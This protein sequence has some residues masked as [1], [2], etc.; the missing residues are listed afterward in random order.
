VI[1]NIEQVAV[2]FHYT[3]HSLRR[4]ARQGTLP[5]AFKAG[6]Q[7]RVDM[8]MLQKAWSP[9]AVICFDKNYKGYV[10]I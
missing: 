2:I 5:G 1:A 8:D 4:M 10:K 9:H 7:W 3:P 6:K